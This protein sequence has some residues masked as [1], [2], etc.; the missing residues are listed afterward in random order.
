MPAIR[1][2]FVAD[3]EVRRVPQAVFDRLHDGKERMAEYA[4]QRVRYAFFFLET[5]DREPVAVSYAEFNVLV[6]DRQGRI[7]P[8]AKAEGMRLAAASISSV[9]EGRGEGS[10]IQA[11]ARFARKRYAD[12]FKW[13]PTPEELARIYVALW[14]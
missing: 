4:E 7:D 9:L 3:S 8:K 11:G 6:F 13:K 12:T 10:L 2:F 1:I 14:K 5:E